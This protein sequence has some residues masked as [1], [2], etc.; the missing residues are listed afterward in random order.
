MHGLCRSVFSLA[1]DPFILGEDYHEQPT[2]NQNSVIVEPTTEF[3][4][5]SNDIRASPTLIQDLNQAV[6][7]VKRSPKPPST[8]LPEQHPMGR[9]PSAAFPP[10]LLL[11]VS[12]AAQSLQ[13]PP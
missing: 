5:A 12:L 9:H 7:R 6:K 1:P 10:P 4:S 11:L 8:D 3:N 13:L 2:K